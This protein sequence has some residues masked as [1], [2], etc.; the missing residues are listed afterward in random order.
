MSVYVGFIKKT[1]C[2]FAAL[3]PLAAMAQ[4]YNADSVR[5]LLAASR[6]NSTKI[7]ALTKL[8]NYYSNFNPDSEIY[9]AD[10]LK[11][12]AI[13][14]KNKSAE[15]YATGNIGEG[16]FRKGNTTQALA[17]SFKAL[18][19]F[20]DIKDSVNVAD[21]YNDLG[22]I[23]QL[24]NRKTALDYYDKCR[25]ISEKIHDYTDVYYAYGNLGIVYDQLNKLDSSIYCLKKAIAVHDARHINYSNSYYIAELSTVYDKLNQ[26]A[27]A[28]A[29]L[30]AAI[31]LGSKNDDKRTFHLQ[32]RFAEHFADRSEADSGLQY[33]KPV[34]SN[35]TIQREPEYA[36]RLYRVLARLYADKK[37]YELAYQYQAKSIAADSTLYNA[38]KEQQMA[39]LTFNEKQHKIDLESAAAAYQ[40]K[41]RLYMALLVLIVVIAFTAILWNSYRK[42][43]KANK[44][45]SRQ[46]QQIQ[47]TLQEL[48]ST[49]AQLIQSE[50]MASLGELTAGIAHEIQ[51]P[52]N[53]VN[54]F[55]EVNQ[56][57]ID[58]LKAELK[59]GNVD[60]ALA[61]ADD[62][63][64]NEEKI[65][66]HGKRADSIVKGMLQH[67]RTGS[68]QKELTNLNNL[69]DEYMRLSYHG[70]RSKDK[71]FNTETI[72]HFDAKLPLI[73]F[74]PRI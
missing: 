45:L 15:G 18:R 52:L 34:L 50:K 64:Q 46:K 14:I 40:S 20:E 26:H 47:H 31:K 39:N 36:G 16:F 60:E 71:N 72:T 9:Y 3:L 70:L 7:D 69:A 12:Y 4:I 41:L 35:P 61:I 67:S 66:H 23:Y 68:A 10:I 6:V 8:S 5:A 38:N 21:I 54:N 43:Q 17:I 53:F 65:S 74:I 24:H 2:F 30:K 56:E 44:L 11:N 33:A 29:I 63:Q 28:G 49:Q 32:L 25:L 55:A 27:M 48:E 22:N 62:I 13:K 37:Q 1:V 57:M 19:I 42:Q 58:E 73:N 51:N 59:S